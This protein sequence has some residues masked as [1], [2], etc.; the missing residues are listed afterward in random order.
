MTCSNCKGK[1]K[2]VDK[3]VRPD[4]VIFR[5]KKCV[6]CG[7]KVATMEFAVVEDELF[8]REWGKHHRLTKLHEKENK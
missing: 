8:K 6:A 3:V 7:E 1:L 5:K 2:V 4:N